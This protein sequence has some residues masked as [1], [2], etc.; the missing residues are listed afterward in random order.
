MK[1]S[2]RLKQLCLTVLFLSAGILAFSQEPLKEKL[3]ITFSSNMTCEGCKET[4]TRNLSFEKGVTGL[5][6]DLENNLITIEYKNRRTD[7]MKLRKAIEKI[8][9]KAEEIKDEEQE[10][11]Q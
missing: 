8:G 4:I 11:E 10:K 1:T 9:Y 7:P 3:S 5:K 6:V 2:R